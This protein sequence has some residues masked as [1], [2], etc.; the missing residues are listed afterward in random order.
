MPV[1]KVDTEV[2]DAILRINL[3]GTMIASRA[4][5][6]HLRK[7]GGAIIN[8][9][10]NAAL[11]GAPV[12][13]R[14]QR[15]EGGDQLADAEHRHA[16]RQGRHP[17]QRDLAGPDRHAG[18][19]GQLCQLRRRRHHA[20]PPPHAAARAARGHRRGG[21]LPGLRRGRL[22]HRPGDLRRWR[23]ARAPALRCRLHGQG[24]RSHERS[25][26]QRL[27]RVEAQLAIQQLPARYA[28]AVDSRNLDDLVALSPWTSIAAAGA[29][30]ARR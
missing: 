18:H 15:V 6:P 16:A 21:R 17:L 22:H 12:A 24:S 23:F 5:I 27:E 25:I 3:R 10:S 4:A 2:W 29:K 13:Q 1:E 19:A 14:L 11:A 30:A 7:R 20:A 9:S 26:E 28:L 8:T